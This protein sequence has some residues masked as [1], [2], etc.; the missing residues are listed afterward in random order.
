MASRS[1]PDRPR[2]PR[3]ARQPLFDS[4]HGGKLVVMPS[5]PRPACF[6]PSEGRQGAE[7]AG[8][9]AAPS[10]FR[11]KMLTVFS[12]SFY[13]KRPEITAFPAIRRTNDRRA[14]NVAIHED[15]YDTLL[16]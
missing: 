7:E 4:H 5:E 10:Y 9:P 16:K 3:P 1:S 6:G 15:A 14:D 8:Q 2:A 11:L 13:V 12:I